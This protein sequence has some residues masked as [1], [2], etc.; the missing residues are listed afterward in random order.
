MKIYI[1]DNTEY[2][3]SNCTNEALVDDCKKSQQKLINKNKK[4]QIEFELLVE[5]PHRSD[6][7]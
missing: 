5:D 3:P 1:G 7:L 6:V 4:P 2:R